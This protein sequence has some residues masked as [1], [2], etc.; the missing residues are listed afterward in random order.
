MIKYEDFEKIIKSYLAENEKWDRLHDVMNTIAPD[1]YIGI[2][3]YNELPIQILQLVFDDID[4]DWI[5]Y[6]MYE[7]DCG[8]EYYEGAVTDADGHPIC[9]ETCQDLYALLLTEMGWEVE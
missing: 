9:L 5:N 8:A 1:T 4:N 2:P 6:W 3:T 7:L